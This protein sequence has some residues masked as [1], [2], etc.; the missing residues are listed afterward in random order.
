LN[1]CYL[2][3]AGGLIE[4]VVGVVFDQLAAECDALFVVFDVGD[5]SG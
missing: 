5:V 3:C 1:G 2:S 4:A